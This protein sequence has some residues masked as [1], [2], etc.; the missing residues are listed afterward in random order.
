MGFCSQNIYLL[1]ANKLAYDLHMIDMRVMV[2]EAGMG[3]TAVGNIYYPHFCFGTG[4]CE[5][6]LHHVVVPC[7]GAP[8][9]LR[10]QNHVEGSIVIEAW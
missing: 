3:Q 8:H 6:L 7:D 2:E 10:I 9:H 1:S 5:N 4:L